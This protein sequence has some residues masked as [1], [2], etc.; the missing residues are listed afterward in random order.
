MNKTRIGILI[1][2]RGTNMESIITSCKQNEIPADVVVVISNK[3][4][5]LGL[6]KAKEF[7]IPT[8]VIDHS[9]Y[10][11][12]EEFDEKVRDKLLE[13]N[14]ELV[15][16]A[17]F[18]RIISSVLIDAF[19]NKIMNIHPALLP[20]F[21]GLNVQ[22]KAIKYGVKFS[23]CTVHFVDNKVDHGPIVVQAVVPVLPDDDEDSLSARILASEHKIYSRAIQ[24]FAEKRLKIKGRRVFVDDYDK[25]PGPVIFP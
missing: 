19:K 13:F 4:D 22:K 18:M 10:S 6:K 1:S 21:P 5:A 11:T 24:L 8:V 7:N 25:E 23:G 2:G 9:G 16:L 14:V 3:S 12:R 17:G 20:A 15:C